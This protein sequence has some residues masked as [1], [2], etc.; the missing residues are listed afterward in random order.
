[1]KISELKH[2]K[3]VQWPTKDLEGNRIYKEFEYISNF[4]PIYKNNESERLA[5]K[6]IDLSLFFLILYLFTEKI[7]FSITL[8]ILCVI[9][10]GSLLDHLLG[11]TLGKSIFKI[12]VIDDY[13]KYPNLKKS[14]KRNFL[15][16]INLFP[17]FTEGYTRMGV[18][19]MKINFNMHLNN[20]FC[21]TYIVKKD[22]MDKIKVMLRN[23]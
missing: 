16:L 10:Y 11:T 7:I 18:S 22:M 14:F 17:T 15:C 12:R 8:A 20:K 3:V 2:Q 23:K 4:N 1:L 6:L 13:A 9:I 21:K 5:A 19:I